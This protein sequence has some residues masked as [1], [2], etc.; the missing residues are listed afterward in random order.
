MHKL[1]LVLSIVDCVQ[2]E[3]A[4]QKA[5][6]VSRS[7]QEQGILAGK[8]M[9]NFDFIWQNAMQYSVLKQVVHMINPLPGITCY[10]KCNHELDKHT[11]LG[12]FLF[13]R[14]ELHNLKTGLA[15]KTKST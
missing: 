8:M 3:V 11:S 15:W 14:N 6:N 2:P 1:S 4:Y 13:F 12:T 5:D 7:S 10:M 9:E